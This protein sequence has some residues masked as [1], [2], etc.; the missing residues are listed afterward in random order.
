MD[1]LQVC[2]YGAPY[3]G[4]FIDSLLLLEE[5]LMEA[6]HTTIYAFAETAKGKPWC[7]EI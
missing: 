2:A 1:I 4:N 3:P 7:E 5:K 6:G